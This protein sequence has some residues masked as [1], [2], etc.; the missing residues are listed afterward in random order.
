M[1]YGQNINLR[2]NIVKPKIDIRKPHYEVARNR[3]FFPVHKNYKYYLEATST[4]ENGITTYY[5]LVGKEEFNPNCRRCEVNGIGNCRVQLHNDVKE[6]ITKECAE[7]GNI[8]ATLI[9]ENS[10]YDTYIIT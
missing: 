7:R 4:D 3:F 8:I 1:C 2:F 9:D 10:D 6:Y 5:I